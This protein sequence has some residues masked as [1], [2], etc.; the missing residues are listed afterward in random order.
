MESSCGAR[1]SLIILGT[2]YSPSVPIGTIGTPCLQGA[3][4]DPLVSTGRSSSEFSVRALLSFVPFVFFV[5]NCF[6]LT[7]EFWI[8][9]PGFFLLTTGY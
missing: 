3:L 8:L 1:I 4:S 9:A 7:P 5:V 6:F 2:R